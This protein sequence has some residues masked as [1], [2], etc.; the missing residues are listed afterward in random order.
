MVTFAPCPAGA[1]RRTIAL[2]KTTSPNEAS[3][4]GWIVRDAAG[5]EI[6]TR[7]ECLRLLTKAPVGRIAVTDRGLP[8]IHPVN[9]GLDGDHIVFRTSAANKLAAATRDAIVAFE[10]DEF[11]TRQHTG[12]SVMVTGRASAVADADELN[13]LRDLPLKS[14]APNQPEHFVEISLDIV[15]GRRVPPPDGLPD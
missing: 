5:L 1:G 4:R 11:D 14:W 6:L 9:Y 2:A 8:V 7:D 3:Q 10:V 13:R 15:T 12:W